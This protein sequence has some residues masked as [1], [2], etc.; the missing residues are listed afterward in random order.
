[1]LGL[2]K[3]HYNFH[4]C[5]FVYISKTSFPGTDL[6]FPGYQLFYL[7]KNSGYKKY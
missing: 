7:Y 2:P 3:G 1:M 4:S 6:D 5:S